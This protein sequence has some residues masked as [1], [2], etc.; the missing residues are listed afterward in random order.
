MKLAIPEIHVGREKAEKYVALLCKELNLPVPKGHEFAG[1]ITVNNG[2]QT[3]E[4]LLP[5][6][7]DT[8]RRT[9]KADLLQ[10]IFDSSD[11]FLNTPLSLG[12][13][14]DIPGVKVKIE[15]NYGSHSS[16]VHF[17]GFIE[18]PETSFSHDIVFY[19][20]QAVQ[21][22]N[23]EDLPGFARAYRGYLQ[24][25]VSLVECF[26]YRYTFHVKNMIPSMQEFDNTAKLD[27]RLSIDDRLDAWMTTF[28]IHKIKDFKNSKSRSKF[29]EL[30]NQRNSIVHPT[31]PSVPYSV[32]DVV[33]FLNYCQDGV[34]G[35]LG[36]LRRYAGYTE[37]IGFI[38]QI[39]SQGEV[40]FA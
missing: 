13:S 26:I 3:T 18:P 19:R 27:S 11:R 2:A 25:C 33:K 40:R 12:I 20:K 37:N 35:L 14:C 36:D 9:G 38:K 7:V 29:L 15:S 31:N 10:A 24:S 30:K 23:R 5:K 28:A 8:V 17:S 1:I 4:I 16:F 22:F 6:E 39:R 32:K 21:S 34:G